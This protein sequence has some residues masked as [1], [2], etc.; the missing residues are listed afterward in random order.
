MRSPDNKAPPADHAMQQVA[1]VTASQALLWRALEAWAVTAASKRHVRSLTAYCLQAYLHKLCRRAFTAWRT[2]ATHRRAAWLQLCSAVAHRHRVLLKRCLAAWLQTRC[3][4]QGS[5]SAHADSLCAQQAIERSTM[6]CLLIAEYIDGSEEGQQHGPVLTAVAERPAIALSAA[7]HTVLPGEQSSESPAPATRHHLPPQASPS[8]SCAQ[9]PPA[10]LQ[11][12]FLKWRRAWHEARSAR[13]QAAVLFKRRQDAVLV[14]SPCL[15]CQNFIKVR[16]SA[17]LPQRTC[18]RSAV[19]MTPAS[20]TP[21]MLVS[22]GK[23]NADGAPDFVCRKTHLLSGRQKLP[24]RD[25][26]T[27]AS[28]LLQHMQPTVL[29]SRKA[30]MLGLL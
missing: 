29:A 1:A 2:R 17:F 19:K 12:V 16:L 8:A 7:E 10:V 23:C 15:L 3:K 30:L 27:I 28:C 11:H 9:T 21:Q 24:E 20:G 18:F 22:L 5:P 25:S 26:I 13:A 14:C 6:G 4:S